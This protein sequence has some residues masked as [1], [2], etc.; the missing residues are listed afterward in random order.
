MYFLLLIFVSPCSEEIHLSILPKQ[1]IVTTTK[2][3][4]K[5]Y[6]FCFVLFLLTFGDTYLMLPDI[7]MARGRC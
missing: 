7:K 4:I 3:T 1:K 6:L 2:K 5:D